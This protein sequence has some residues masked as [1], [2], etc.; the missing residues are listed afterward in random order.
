MHQRTQDAMTYVRK[1][2]NADLFI[3]FT[4][5]PKWSEITEELKEYQKPVP[6]HDLVA[7]VFRQ[8]LVLLMN[9]LTEG[10]IFGEDEC[11]MYTIEWQKRG[12]PLAHIILWLNKKL[13][14]TK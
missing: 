10:H 1:Y 2:G 11:Y 8:N 14:A 13:H 6:R 3:T 12:L 5:N 7:K 4:S 9:F